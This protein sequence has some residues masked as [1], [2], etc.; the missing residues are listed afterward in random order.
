M[1]GEESIHEASGDI[2]S[3]DVAD[4]RVSGMLQVVWRRF[5]R[6]FTI[7]LL[8]GLETRVVHS[9][10]LLIPGLEAGVDREGLRKRVGGRS[11]GDRESP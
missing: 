10:T 11:S 8:V 2:V 4:R 6:V 1:R 7:V 5:G 9:E 3:L